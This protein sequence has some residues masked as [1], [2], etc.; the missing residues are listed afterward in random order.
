MTPDMTAALDAAIKHGA[1]RGSMELAKLA[2]AYYKAVTAPSDH[3]MLLGLIR[4]LLEELGESGDPDVKA[5]A[6]R[7]LARYP[8][9]EA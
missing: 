8:V 9:Q 6:H 5:M 2:E 3:T 1:P 7:T 4:V